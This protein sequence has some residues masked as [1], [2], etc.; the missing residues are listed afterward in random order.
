MWNL[1]LPLLLLSKGRM[2]LAVQLVFVLFV[3][4]KIT[5]GVDTEISSVDGGSVM[6]PGVAADQHGGVKVFQWKKA[7]GAAGKGSPAKAMLQ[8]HSG[9]RGAAVVRSYRG[10]VTF[11]PRNGSMAFLNVTRRDAGLYLLYVNLQRDAVQSVRL[12]VMD[13]LSEVSLWSNSS[14]LGSTVQLNCAVTGTPRQYQ[15]RKDGRPVS[16]HHRLLNGNAS[17][18]IPRAS[19]VD[20]GTYTCIV[21][22]PVSFARENL[23]LTLYGVPAEQIVAMMVWASG[24]LYSSLSLIGSTFLRVYKHAST[25][26]SRRILFYLLTWLSGWNTPSLVIVHIAVISWVVLKGTFTVPTGS[27]Y[28]VSALFLTTIAFTA[29]PKLHHP[30]FLK[31]VQL[32]GFKIVLEFS[33]TIVILT[34][35]IELKETFQ[36]M[37]QGCH[38]HS[39]SWGTFLAS[40]TV[41]AVIF[42]LYFAES[43]R[44]IQTPADP[45]GSGEKTA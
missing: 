35:I 22:N 27:L 38:S 15:W 42:S 24:L 23:T 39:L 13:R 37:N 40:T 12:L 43:H 45:E 7:G 44:R 30:G 1:S 14:S 36:Q 31:F 3:P 28:I 33:P 41:G 11:F 26:E 9:S 17:L 2:Y 5:R 6:F 10:R 16:R 8:F 18:V 29:I 20:C 4:T 25:T 34:S 32:T 19:R 21:S